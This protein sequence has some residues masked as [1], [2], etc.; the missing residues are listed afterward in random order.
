MGLIAVLSALSGIL[1]GFVLIALG[2]LLVRY[3]S[4]FS[5]FKKSSNEPIDALDGAEDTRQGVLANALSVFSDSFNFLIAGKQVG[6]P[7]DTHDEN[8][9][10]TVILIGQAIIVIGY[11]TILTAIISTLIMFSMRNKIGF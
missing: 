4:T 7:T 8:T 6:K 1:F 2:V 9:H 11:I 5:Y 10:K 3:K